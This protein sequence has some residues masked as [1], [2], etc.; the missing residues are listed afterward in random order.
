QPVP[1]LKLGQNHD[2]LVSASLLF[3]LVQIF[4]N[5]LGQPA[6][7]RLEF[8]QFH[9]ELQM[10]LHQLLPLLLKAGVY[11]LSSSTCTACKAALLL[12]S[13]ID[14]ANSRPSRVPRV[15]EGPM[16]TTTVRGSA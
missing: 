7:R 8:L 14:R 10:R 4:Q 1:R 16:R 6:I 13:T 15:I 12:P 3:Q 5:W 11:S 2:D 9:R